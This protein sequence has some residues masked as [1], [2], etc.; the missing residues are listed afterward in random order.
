MIGS[1]QTSGYYAERPVSANPGSERFVWVRKAGPSSHT[2]LLRMTTSLLTAS[3]VAV[4]F[5]AIA[6]AQNI[7]RKPATLPEE[8]EY[9]VQKDLDAAA[10]FQS[11]E[12]ELDEQITTEEINLTTTTTAVLLISG[13]GDCLTSSGNVPYLMYAKFGN[14]WRKILHGEGQAFTALGVMHNGWHDVELSFK[15]PGA[16]SAHYLYSFNKTEYKPESCELR[17]DE[18]T[19]EKTQPKPCPGWKK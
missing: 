12:P 4:L 13:K 16:E 17:P 3:L 5:T 14:N 7:T 10:C 8:L 18:S 6:V 1:S 9:Q 19:T 11:E 15:N 2:A